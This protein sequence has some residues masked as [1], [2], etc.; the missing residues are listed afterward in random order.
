MSSSA[1]CIDAAASTVMCLPCGNGGDVT[2][3]AHSAPPAIAARMSE[4]SSPASSRSNCIRV[5]AGT[6]HNYIQFARVSQEQLSVDGE[7][8]RCPPWGQKFVRLLVRR[9]SDRMKRHG[10]LLET[11]HGR[12]DVSAHALLGVS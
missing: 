5:A 6:T 9:Q 8:S 11:R 1:F 4:I 10:A 7:V 12:R 2:T 3:I